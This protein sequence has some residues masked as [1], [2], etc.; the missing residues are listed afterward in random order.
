MVQTWR[1]RIDYVT[2]LILYIRTDVYIYATKKINRID[3]TCKVYPHPVVN[4]YAQVVQNGVFHH[5]GSASR[6]SG[7]DPVHPPAWKVYIK[8]AGYGNHGSRPGLRIERENND[9]V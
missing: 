9:A 7:I 1:V 4:L 2:A 8:I 3:K 6:I 5:F